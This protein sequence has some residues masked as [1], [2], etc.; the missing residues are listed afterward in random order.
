[1]RS[2]LTGAAAALLACLVPLAPA[3]AQSG[4]AATPATIDIVFNPPLDTPL[5]YRVVRDRAARKDWPAVV[6]NWVEELHFARA[7][8]GFVAHWRM[9]PASLPAEMHAPTVAPMVAPFTGT[10]IAFDL[11]AEGNVLRVRDWPAAQARM[12]AAVDAAAAIIPANERDRVMPQIRAMFTALTAETA[13]SMLLRNVD[14]LFGG[15]GLS[16]KVGEAI[17]TPMAQQVPLLGGSVTMDVTVTLT[18]AEPGRTATLVSRSEIDPESLKQL[19]ARMV[20]RFGT[21]RDGE[22]LKREFAEKMPEMLVT[23][24]STTLIDLPSGMPLRFESRRTAKIDGKE[25]PVETL[26]LSWLH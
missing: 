15:G 18:T 16:M 13:P 2:I 6:T 22:K 23:E 10:P 14:P 19:M 1:M 11:D 20:D 12:M 8:D 17:R 5:R 4:A 24:G 7:G 26:T 21:S 25:V 3:A 9:D